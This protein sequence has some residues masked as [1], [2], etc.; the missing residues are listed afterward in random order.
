MCG[1][2]STFLDARVSTYYLVTINARVPPGTVGDKGGPLDISI[3]AQSGVQLIRLTGDLR[4]GD[5]VEQFRKSTDELLGSGAVR[6]VVNV[7]A[8]RMIDSSGIGALVRLLTAATKGGGG[9]RLV[10]PSKF[11]IQTLKLTGLLSIIPVYDDETEAIA[12]FN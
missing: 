11:T 9:M 12:S 8:V 3:R 6:L 10:Q 4:L 5:P 2:C 1:D 7:A